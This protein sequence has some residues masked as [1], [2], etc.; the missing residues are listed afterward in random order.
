MTA[1]EKTKKINLALQGGGSHG[2]FA[3][4]ALNRI[5]EEKRIEIEA[6][7]AT[8]AGTMNALALS[9]GMH[10]GGHDGARDMLEKFW[11]RLSEIGDTFGPIRRT[12]WEKLFSW[13]VDYSPA[14][15]MFDTLTR[16]LS[17]E[18][19]NPLGINP[20]RDLLDEMID[21]DGLRSCDRLKLFISATHVKSGR[22]KVFET[23]DITLD[24]AM[25]SACLPQTFAPVYVDDEAYWDGGYTGN[26]ALYPLFYKTETN[27]LMIIHLNPI[28]RDT[29]PS[30]APEIAN[31]LNEINFN[32]SLLF[33]IRAIA[34]VK[35]LLDEDMLKP[36]FRNKFK[37]ISLH[38]IRAD[39]ALKDLSVASK[40]LTDWDFLSELRDSGY[41]AMDEWLGENFESIGKKSTVDMNWEFLNPEQPKIKHT[42]TKPLKKKK[43]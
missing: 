2:A 38:S 30:T 12:P 6:I 1:S 17:P 35:K 3:W 20:L 34:F 37:N 19:W 23:S 26:P 42:K 21:F 31:R 24:V 32:S 14:Y 10:L 5:L 39:K 22:V 29:V 41:A 11:R 28:E 27:D 16:E 4:G 15:N 25:A 13:S 33:E 40:F 8:S 36:E 9:Y 43:S 18:Q 7:T